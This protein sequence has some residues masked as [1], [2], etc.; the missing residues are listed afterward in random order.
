ME[1]EE[2]KNYDKK[3]WK[4]NIFVGSVTNNLIKN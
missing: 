2:G 1:D 3:N 4:R